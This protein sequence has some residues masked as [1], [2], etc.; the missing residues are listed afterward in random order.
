MRFDLYTLKRKGIQAALITTGAL[1][2]SFGTTFTTPKLEVHAEDDST[3]DTKEEIEQQ[4]Q[5]A[6]EKA[7][8]SCGECRKVSEADR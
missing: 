5:D 6:E 7:G 2:M 8:R 4:K 1:L 3:G